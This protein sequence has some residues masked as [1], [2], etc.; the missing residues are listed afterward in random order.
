MEPQIAVGIG[1][2]GPHEGVVELQRG[3]Q[4]VFPPTKDAHLPP[5]GEFGSHG[6][7]RVEGRD[8][9]AGGPQSFGQRALRDEFGID[10]AGL[11][12][13]GE[14]QHVAG[15]RGGGEGADHL[16]NPT[17]LHQHADIGHARLLRAAGGVGDQRKVPRA[18]V[19]QRLD[20]IERRARHGEPAEAD[21]AA[22]RDIGDGLR[23]A[24]A[25]FRLLRHRLPGSQ[26]V[27]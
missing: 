24:V 22:V 13:P 16:G 6:G 25:V 15:A 2:A 19:E 17:V 12:V 7:R 27:G 18:L 8:A 20:E 1:A 4:Q 5:L 11:V 21:G 10:L 14:G 9:G 3:F 23:E 26:V